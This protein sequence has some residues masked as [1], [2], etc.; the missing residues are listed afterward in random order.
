MAG[1]RRQQHPFSP[2][3]GLATSELIRRVPESGVGGTPDVRP[4]PKSAE[5]TRF[6]TLRTR[7]PSS[8]KRRFQALCSRL[9]ETLDTPVCPSHVLR[10]LVSLCHDIE[11]NLLLEA[12]RSAGVRR[13]PNDEAEALKRFDH[14][15]RTLIHRALLN[16]SYLQP[17]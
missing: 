15:I 9:G 4:M 5:S 6:G 17:R 11:P 13:P 16:A 8:D 3:D 1:R 14:A 7:V 12:R 10:A 2:L